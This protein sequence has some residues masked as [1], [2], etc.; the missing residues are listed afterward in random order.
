MTFQTIIIN[1]LIFSGL[2][3]G[4]TTFYTEL[5]V[6]YGVDTTDISSFDQTL[7]AT[8]QINTME[9]TIR[10]AQNSPAAFVDV[11]ATGTFNTINLIFSTPN[12]IASILVDIGSIVGIP[13]WVTSLVLGGVA[14]IILM[15]FL[16]GIIKL[17]L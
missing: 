9:E 3:I 17:E 10:T 14:T 4:M 1:I 6:N 8:Q 16:R 13:T 7:N 2:V 5:H 11:I 12:I 15:L